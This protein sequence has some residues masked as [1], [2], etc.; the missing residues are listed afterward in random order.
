MTVDEKVGS[1]IRRQRGKDEGQRLA[2]QKPANEQAKT[3]AE[4]KFCRKKL[5]IPRPRRAA[6][7]ND[8]QLQR[9]SEHRDGLADERGSRMAVS[10]PQRQ[11]PVPGFEGRASPPKNGRCRILNPAILAALLE[12]TDCEPSDQLHAVVPRN[13]EPDPM[14]T[15]AR[16][17][18]HNERSSSR[19][20]MPNGIF[21]AVLS[22]P[23]VLKAPGCVCNKLDRLR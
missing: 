17:G 13:K 8:N 9:V 22:E 20:A 19:C 15:M 7:Q 16:S 4:Q 21:G 5:D 12:N 23:S 6:T 18:S 2:F 14:P 10:V 3:K 1:A 11:F